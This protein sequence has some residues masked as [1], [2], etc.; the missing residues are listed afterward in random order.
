MG[1]IVLAFLKKLPMMSTMPM[2]RATGARVEGWKKRSTLEPPASTSN[3]RMIWPVT[4]VPTLAPMMMPR[5]WCRVSIPAPTR[6][7]VMTMV[8]VELWIRAVTRTPRIKAFR[9]LSV[10]F[11]MITFRVPEEFS[12]KE[13]PM[14]RMPYRNMARPPRREITLNISINDSLSRVVVPKFS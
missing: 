2:M 13:S 8:A 7:A 3:R 5:L 6:P 10:T 12:F 14:S 11:P 1:Q 4:V 9:G